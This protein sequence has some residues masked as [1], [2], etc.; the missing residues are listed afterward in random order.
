MAAGR[1]PAARI[2]PEVGHPDELILDEG[3][4]AQEGH[5]LRQGGGGAEQQQ[6]QCAHYFSLVRVES[7]S[8][9][10]V[11]TRLFIS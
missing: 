7:I 11:M 10:A 5:L 6:D 3:V 1:A 9:E 2:V 4:G 8:S